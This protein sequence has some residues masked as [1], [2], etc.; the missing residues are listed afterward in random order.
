MK[1]VILVSVLFASSMA[2]A[3]GSIFTV[4]GK[5]KSALAAEFDP[6]VVGDSCVVEVVTKSGRVFRLVS[7][8]DQCTDNQHE[9]KIGRG[10]TVVVERK[11]EVRNREAL[12]ILR[13]ATNSHS[14]Y[15]VDFGAI[16]NGLAD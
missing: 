7:D 10:I 3:A 15:K 4:E 1:T 6:M 16:E 2:S 11:D 12:K 5:I 13:E 8:F 9:L 14:Y